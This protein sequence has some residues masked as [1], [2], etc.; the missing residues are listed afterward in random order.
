MD[1][2]AI[3]KLVLEKKRQILKEAAKGEKIWTL[4]DFVKHVDNVTASGEEPTL[5]P[6]A[7]MVIQ[8]LDALDT[9]C[10][11][12]QVLLERMEDLCKDMEDAKPKNQT[13]VMGPGAKDAAD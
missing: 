9:E 8:L 7:L 3:E 12:N 4:D 13:F 6:H 5:C 11:R 2:T 10:K 1:R